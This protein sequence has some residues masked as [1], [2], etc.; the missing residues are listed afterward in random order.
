MKKYA[1]TH[2][3]EASP[4]PLEGEKWRTVMHGCVFAVDGNGCVHCW[5]SSA[6]PRVGWDE[7]LPPTGDEERDV[8]RAW[9]LEQTARA[10]K[11]EAELARAE[12]IARKA[13]GE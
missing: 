10:E 9:G 2:L 11:A 13:L 7:P 4:A 8:L 6:N 1:T 12:Q 5:W 3:G